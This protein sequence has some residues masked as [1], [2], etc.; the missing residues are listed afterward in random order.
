MKS[1][2]VLSFLVAFLVLVGSNFDSGPPVVSGTAVSQAPGLSPGEEM[3]LR[4]VANE[5]K[6]S[7]N[8]ESA[9]QKLTQLSD[10]K[11]GSPEWVVLSM[12]TR[13]LLRETPEF[14][15]K[16]ELLARYR[17]LVG[18]YWLGT[19]DK[20]ADAFMKVT[21]DKWVAQIDRAFL[22]SGSN[23]ETSA[24]KEKV[25]YVAYLQYAFMSRALAYQIANVEDGSFLN[26]AKKAG[27][28]K[29]IFK[30]SISG[31]TW[32]YEN[33]E[34]KQNVKAT[35]LVQVEKDHYLN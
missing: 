35:L 34:G 29:V 33:L 5:A 30:N 14:K 21:T 27:F 28:E 6:W 32:V 7:Q 1:F 19:V 10:L 3:E 12:A 23:I 13:D 4:N 16:S 31:T 18:P 2:L 17:S 9:T 26:L 24:K 15:N 8:L 20:T 22:E 11:E 25:G